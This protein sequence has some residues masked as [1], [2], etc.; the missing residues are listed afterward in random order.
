MTDRKIRKQITVAAAFLLILIGIQLLYLAKLSIWDGNEL[1][2][3]PLN[4]RSALMEQDI[5]RGCIIQ[6]AVCAYGAGYPAWVY[7]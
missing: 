6:H 5:R 2:A 1:S 7:P 3:H 4:M